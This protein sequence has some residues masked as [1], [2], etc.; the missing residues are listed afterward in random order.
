[1]I[2]SVTP[3]HLEWAATQGV[4]WV[5]PPAVL[6]T[7]LN[8]LI[9]ASNRQDRVIAM[10]VRNTPGGMEQHLRARDYSYYAE[11]FDREEAAFDR[12]MEG[13]DRG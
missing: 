1:L 11:I 9:E 3:N 8:E 10:L 12:E 5:L 2:E 13:I 4:E 7:K 6:V